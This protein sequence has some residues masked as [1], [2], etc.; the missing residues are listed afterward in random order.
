M[1]ANAKPVPRQSNSRTAPPTRTDSGGIDE[2]GQTAAQ[3]KDDRDPDGDRGVAGPLAAEDDEGEQA[4]QAKRR[5]GEDHAPVHGVAPDRGRVVEV[6]RL[7]PWQVQARLSRVLSA[8]RSNGL[9][10]YP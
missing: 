1:A 9:G 4:R 10:A 8:P 5:G 7:L 3:H 6:G 2:G